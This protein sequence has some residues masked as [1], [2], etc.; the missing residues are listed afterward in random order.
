[1]AIYRVKVDRRFGAGKQYGPGDLVELSEDEAA[2]FVD[3][4]EPVSE[5]DAADVV[6]VESDDAPAKPA[7]AKK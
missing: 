2:A 3:L 1:M 4:V 5:A 6:R 7:K